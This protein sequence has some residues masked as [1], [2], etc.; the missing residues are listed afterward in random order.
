M[1]YNE[2]PVDIINGSE[3]RPQN[4]TEFGDGRFYLLG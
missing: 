4:G 1:H 2:I 3:K